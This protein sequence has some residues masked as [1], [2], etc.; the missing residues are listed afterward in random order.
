[1]LTDAHAAPA[2]ARGSLQDDGITDALG[3][4]DGFLGAR[5]N[6]RGAGQRG[7]AVFLHDGAGA[8]LHAH[9]L[10]YVRLRT[11]ELDAGILADLGEARVLAQ[12]S[13]AGMDGIDVGDLRRADDGRNIQIAAGALGRTDADGFVG[14]THRQAVAIRFGIDGDGGNARDRGRR[15]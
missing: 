9:G 12:E 7:N 5:K 3:E 11:D 13:I 14:E 15:R 2:A 1:M 6:A 10:N 8:F 4:F